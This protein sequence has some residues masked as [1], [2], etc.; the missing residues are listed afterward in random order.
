MDFG[1]SFGYIFF[2]GVVCLL[3]SLMVSGELVLK[4]VELRYYQLREVDLEETSQELH[5]I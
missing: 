5:H 2:M 4:I 1:V 3:L